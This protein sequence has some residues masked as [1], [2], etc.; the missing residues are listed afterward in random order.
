MSQPNKLPSFLIQ[1]YEHDKS[2]DFPVELY[3]TPLVID[4]LF[5]PLTNSKFSLGYLDNFSRTNESEECLL[6][7]GH[8]I[9]FEKSDN[10]IYLIKNSCF[11]KI[12][13]LAKGSDEQEELEPRFRR[14]IFNLKPLIE[15]KFFP[16]KVGKIYDECS[17]RI[18]FGKPFEKSQDS[19]LG[20]ISPCWIEMTLNRIVDTFQNP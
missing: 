19:E 15:H 7:I 14:P 8:G 5:S 6:N 9:E 11:Q 16:K 20:Y 12:Y 1:Y 10:D 13:L 18:S 4:G 17:L 2:I 3:Q